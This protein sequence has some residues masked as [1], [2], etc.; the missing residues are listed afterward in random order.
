MDA[1]AVFVQQRASAGGGAQAELMEV[2]YRTGAELVVSGSF[3]RLRDSLIFEASLVDAK[4]GRV[5]RAVG[6][7]DAPIFAPTAGLDVLRSRVMTALALAVN[8]QVPLDYYAISDV[9]TFEAYRSYVEGWDAFWHGDGARSE[10]AFL[11]AAHR[12]TTFGAAAVAAA[13]TASN[14]SHCALIDSISHALVLSG[15]HVERVDELSLQIAVARCHGAN[16][17]MLRL[18]LER[19]ELAPRTSSFRMPAAAAALWANRPAKTREILQ[20]IN[21]DTDLGWSTDTTHFSYFS[22]YTEALHLLGRYEEEFNIATRVSNSAPL[23]RAWL[24]GRAL[25]ARARSGDLLTLI[26]SALTLPAETEL[27]VGLGPYSDGRPQ[28][29]GSAAWVAVWIARELAAHGDSTTSRLVAQRATAW[30]R[31]RSLEE[32]ATPEERLTAGWSLEMSGEFDAAMRMARE[33]ITTD[34]SNV[35][36]RGLLAGLA[37]RTGDRALADSLQGWLA[38]Q[39]GPRVGWSATFYLARDAAL[40]RR[41]DEAVARL[42]ESIG[43]GAWPMWLHIEPAFLTLKARPDFVALTVSH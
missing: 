32:R 22:S 27:S 16:A 41:D 26:D 18:T 36:Y 20:T 10:Q 39:S 21:P 42:R 24:E 2:A 38:A 13:M 29:A 6:P 4:T 35:D 43:L 7:V 31:A 15:R 28:Y 30:Y 34:S 23:T 1:R 17:E 8:Q 3:Y 11:E 12:D 40:A 19:A 37:T 14:F 25:A 33:L 5:L 9:P